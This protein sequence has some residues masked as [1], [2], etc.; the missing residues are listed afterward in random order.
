MCLVAVR[1]VRLR[2]ILRIGNDAVVASLLRT[3]RQWVHI[4][5][6]CEW[7]RGPQKGDALFDFWLA[8]KEQ[9]LYLWSTQSTARDDW[10][11]PLCG[12]RVLCGMFMEL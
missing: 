8:S 12:G 7:R 4:N 9:R 5:W 6:G 2:G 3:G 10:N 11:H 1:D